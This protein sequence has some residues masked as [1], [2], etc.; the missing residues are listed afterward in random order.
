MTQNSSSYST[1]GVSNIQINGILEQANA[2]VYSNSL[3]VFNIISVSNPTKNNIIA[4]NTGGGI[5]ADMTISNSIIYANA[6][7]ISIS[8]NNSSITMVNSQVTNN[9]LLTPTILSFISTGGSGRI[10]LFGC[11]IIQNSTSSSVSSL[12]RINNNSI[13]TSSSS[14]NNSILL[15]TASTSTAT[16]A[17]ITFSNTE[18]ANTMTFYNNYVKCNCS[19]GSPNNQIILRTGSGAINFTFGNCLGTTG[20]H[21]VPASSG[22]YVKTLMAA[23]V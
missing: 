19:I 4:S 22:S 5:L 2:T 7:N 23:V 18:S 9:P 13:V 16:G 11:T 3:V 20:N 10:N 17:I 8:I 21:T 14:I 15:F 6:D 1:G 12:I